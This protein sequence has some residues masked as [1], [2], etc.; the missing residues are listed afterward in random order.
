MPENAKFL[1]ALPT[2]F[3][4]VYSF[5]TYTIQD[6]VF[7]VYESSILSELGAICE[8]IPPE[9]LSI[10]WDVATEMSIFEGVFSAPIVDSWRTLMARLSRLGDTVLEQVDMGYLLC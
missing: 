9:K 6:Q 10:Q 8:M 1:V 2:P 3:A 5:T 7:P 4:P